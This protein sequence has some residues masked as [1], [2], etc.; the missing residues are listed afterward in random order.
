MKC[1]N[2]NGT[3]TVEDYDMGVKTSTKP[4]HDSKIDVLYFPLHAR[5]SPIVMMLAHQNIDFTVSSVT[6]QD[7]PALKG[8]KTKIP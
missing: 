7:W 5:A 8:D 4:L 1:I 2:A 3:T 6:F